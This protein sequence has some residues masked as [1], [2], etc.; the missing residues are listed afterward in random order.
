MSLLKKLYSNPKVILKKF[1][2]K[3]KNIPSESMGFRAL[4]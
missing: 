1:K 4:P 2:V 3:I